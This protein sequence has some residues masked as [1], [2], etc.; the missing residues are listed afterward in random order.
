MTGCHRFCAHIRK[1]GRTCYHTHTHIMHTH[2]FY[3]HTLRSS[4]ACEDLLFTTFLE[5]FAR[6]CVST[7]DCMVC[8]FFR[9]KKCKNGEKKKSI[10]VQK[11]LTYMSHRGFHAVTHTFLQGGVFNLEPNVIFFKKYFN[12]KTDTVVISA[13]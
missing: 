9:S 7:T 6:H 12:E 4:I 8:V 13:P 3:T 5:L 10:F 2:T 1:E 11:A